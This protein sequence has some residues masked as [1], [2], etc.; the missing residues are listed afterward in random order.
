MEGFIHGNPGPWLS[1]L[2]VVA[3]VRCSALGKWK[4][5]FIIGNGPRVDGYRQY[6]AR[7]RTYHNRK[8]GDGV[9]V[10]EG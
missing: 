3:G 9:E 5:L 2:V 10:R 7:E 1:P 4:Y 6:A 8:E